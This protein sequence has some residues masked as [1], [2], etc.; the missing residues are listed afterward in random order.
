MNYLDILPYMNHTMIVRHVFSRPFMD[1]FILLLFLDSHQKIQ[2]FNI[3]L[4]I[5]FSV[6]C[7]LEMNT[8]ADVSEDI[9]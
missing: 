9:V 7:M 1:F 4:L 5:I 8:W 2:L 3:F 6:V